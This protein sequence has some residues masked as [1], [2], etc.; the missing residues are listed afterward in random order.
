MEGTP[1]QDRIARAGRAG[2]AADAGSVSFQ[3]KEIAEVNPQAGED[4]KWNREARF[5][6]C[7]KDIRGGADG[8]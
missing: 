7:R 3:K 6:Q 2:P 1:R 8:T 5:S 4:E